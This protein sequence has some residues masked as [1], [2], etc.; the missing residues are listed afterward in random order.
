MAPEQEVGWVRLIL[1]KPH[2]SVHSYLHPHPLFMSFLTFRNFLSPRILMSYF[3][4]Q[5]ALRMYVQS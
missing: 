4:E 1:P 5:V 3:Q 2:G